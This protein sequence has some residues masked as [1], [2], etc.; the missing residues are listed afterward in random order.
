LDN[1]ILKYGNKSLIVSGENIHIPR[2]HTVEITL[3]NENRTQILSYE[4]LNIEFMTVKI[5]IK[6]L[7]K[8]KYSTQ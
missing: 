7:I 6:N 1:E 8:I 4:K 3:L 2:N 5:I